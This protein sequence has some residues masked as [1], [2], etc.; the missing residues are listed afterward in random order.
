MSKVDEDIKLAWNKANN[1]EYWLKYKE[2]HK[3]K[4]KER[5]KKYREENRDK[6]N[7]KN[8]EERL[9]EF[10]NLFGIVYIFITYSNMYC[11]S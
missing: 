7:K 6:I 5:S 3:E 4:I 1:H 10:G 11:S 8:Y 2:K 9:K